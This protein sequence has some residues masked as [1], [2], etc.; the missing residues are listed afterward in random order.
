MWP[1]LASQDHGAWA[2]EARFRRRAAA[3]ART[4]VDFDFLREDDT[5]SNRCAQQLVAILATPRHMEPDEIL[6]K[7]WSDVLTG[8]YAV[9][10]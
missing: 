7:H 9:K 1:Y 4:E 3:L 6:A 10:R 2:P 5:Q 8:S